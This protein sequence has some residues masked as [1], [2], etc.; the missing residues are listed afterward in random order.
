MPFPRFGIDVSASPSE[1]PN[2]TSP[3][4]VNV[5]FWDPATGRGKGANRPGISRLL[6][7]VPVPDNGNFHFLIQHLAVVVDPTTEGL[8]DNFD[9]PGA[10]FTDDPSSGPRNPGRRIR[11]GGWARQPNRNRRRTP[12]I[13]WNDPAAIQYGTALSGTQLNASAKDP[14]TGGNVAGSFV[15]SPASGAILPIGP[16]QLLQATFT[17]TNTSLYRTK[18]AKAHIDVIPSPGV[19]ATYRYTGLVVGAGSITTARLTRLFR[20][21]T[22]PGYS[23]SIGFPDG[24]ITPDQDVDIGANYSFPNNMPKIGQTYVIYSADITDPSAA[25]SYTPF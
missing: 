4:M 25:L 21:S 17:P 2:L 20:H 24:Q 5:R 15:Y 14:L 9:Y 11:T 6:P 18:K 3:D 13:T 10:N 22:D 7:R 19:P 23:A 1:Q 16:H 8:L 12:V